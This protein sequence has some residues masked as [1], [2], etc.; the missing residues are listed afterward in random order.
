[1]KNKLASILVFATVSLMGQRAPAQD[2]ILLNNWSYPTASL[3]GQVQIIGTGALSPAQVL[4][5]GLQPIN[6]AVQDYGQRQHELANMI[7][8]ARINEYL[9]QQKFE[10]EVASQQRVLQAQEHI[11]EMRD[12]ID[13]ARLTGA[14]IKA[15]E[16]SDA[17]AAQAKQADEANRA[18]IEKAKAAIEGLTHP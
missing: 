9:Q 4:Q 17:V 7:S 18:K 8:Q 2:G 11:A 12:R 14:L 1:M 5:N 3:P 6:Q 15:Q 16:K 13:Q 10:A